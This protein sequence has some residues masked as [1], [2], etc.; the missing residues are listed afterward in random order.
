MRRWY[1]KAII[2]KLLSW[3]PGGKGLNRFMQTYVTRGLRLTDELINDKLQH[4][5]HHYSAFKKHMDEG[6]KMIVLEL[7]TG[8]FPVVPISM[9]LLGA[10]EI[11]T[12]DLHRL[13]SRK[14]FV[15]TV[16]KFS[17]YH[18]DGNLRKYL[19]KYDEKKLRNLEEIA[20]SSTS[21]E[22][23]LV[24][25]RIDYLVGDIG[26][27]VL[28][29]SHFNLIISN[30]TFEHIYPDTLKNIFVEF[31]RLSS[32]GALMSHFV[33]M[34]DHFSHFDRSISIYHFLKFSNRTWRWID[35]R[36]QPQNRERIS[37][38]REL[39]RSE[40]SKILEEKRRPGNLSELEMIK[41]AAK[42]KDIP[43]P[44]M[45]ISHVYLVSKWA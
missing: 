18:R 33:D 11:A 38:Y 17:E 31:R 20:R 21:L 23:I 39:Y 30:N 45:A 34:S 22:E 12:L 13:M 8:W 32:D 24:E 5:A 4:A 35:N 44:D 19:N 10:S 1:F 26:K 15:R 37:F 16:A 36:I 7:G 6:E 14:N 9:Y 25:V 41:P 29:A 28:Q 40:G 42:F 43:P 27:L 2:Q 3:L